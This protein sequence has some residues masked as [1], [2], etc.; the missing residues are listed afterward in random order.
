MTL[1]ETYAAC[2]EQP[3]HYLTRSIA[4]AL[5]LYCK[6]YDVGNAFAEAPP[7]VD[8]FFMY[9]NAQFHKWWQNDLGNDPIPEGHVIPILKAL[10]GHPEAPRL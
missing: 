10:Q 5:N 3:I 9:L 4:A 2:V 7:P 1:A 8:P 6:G